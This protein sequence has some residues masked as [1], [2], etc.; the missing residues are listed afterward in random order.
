M[1]DFNEIPKN[2]GIKKRSADGYKLLCLTCI[3]N[4]IKENDIYFL[5]DENNIIF[6]Y[7]ELSDIELN[8]IRN[9]VSDRKAKFNELKLQSISAVHCLF[10]L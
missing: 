6:Q 1:N 9:F 8:K 3:E 2:I 7:A 4:A 10:R 5:Q